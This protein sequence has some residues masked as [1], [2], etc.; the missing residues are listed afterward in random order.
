MAS[1]RLPPCGMFESHRLSN[2]GSNI[3]KSCKQ[4]YY[5]DQKLSGVFFA[6][7]KKTL[8][9]AFRTENGENTVSAGRFL[10]DLFCTIDPWHG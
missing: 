9:M 2:V 5:R 10:P 8:D 7:A 6:M 4:R 1:F 3:P